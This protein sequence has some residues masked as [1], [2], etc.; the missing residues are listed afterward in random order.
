MQFVFDLVNSLDLPDLL[1]QMGDAPKP[2][3]AEGGGADGDNAKP[4][5]LFGGGMW[6]F[7]LLMF[8]VM[9]IFMMLSSRPAK[10]QAAKRQEM[11]DSLKKSDRILTA[12][13]I[14]GVVAI[15]EKDN[16]FVSIRIDEASNTKI[17]ILK[18]SI[19]R[20][21]T[22]EDKKGITEEK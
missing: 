14:V 22:D 19:A 18:S 12:G 1:A 6:P 16:D 15:V 3:V 20:I 9:M 11:L 5:G 7:L 21:L 4:G 17:R 2:E 13:G 8:G 10:K